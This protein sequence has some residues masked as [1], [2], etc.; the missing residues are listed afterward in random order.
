MRDFDEGLLTEER[1]A[2]RVECFCQAL[3]VEFHPGD[4][5]GNLDRILAKVER[6]LDRVS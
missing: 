3:E 1:V 2:I 6:L 5:A 4:M